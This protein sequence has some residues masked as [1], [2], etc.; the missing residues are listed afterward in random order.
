MAPL[1]PDC[2]HLDY[3]IWN[4]VKE[5]VYEKRLNKPFEHEKELKKKMES[6]RKDI[7]F[8]LPE[9]QRAIKQFSE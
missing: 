4:K 2:N 8:N 7:A 9:I 1:S 5:K 3:N 6:I